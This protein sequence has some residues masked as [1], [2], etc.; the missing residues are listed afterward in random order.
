MITLET[1]QYGKVNVR[2]AMIDT[3]G[4]NLVEGIEIEVVEEAA[5]IEVAGYRDVEEMTEGEIVTL[6]D[7]ML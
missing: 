2:N 7:T 1:K 6:I 5:T 3:D 4:T